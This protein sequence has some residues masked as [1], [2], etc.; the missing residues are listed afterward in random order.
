MPHYISPFALLVGV[1]VSIVG[2]VLLDR[3]IAQ[4][5]RGGRSRNRS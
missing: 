1:T 5:R 3:L 4:K 2:A